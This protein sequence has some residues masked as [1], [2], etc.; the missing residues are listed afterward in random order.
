MDM[1]MF[2][3]AVIAALTISAAAG[4]VYAQMQQ[5]GPGKTVEISA[6]GDCRRI[7]NTGAHPIMV[8]TR[9]ANE[10]NKGPGAFL[11]NIKQMRGVSA[12][13]C[14]CHIWV[15]GLGAGLVDDRD[16]RMHRIGSTALTW[17]ASLGTGKGDGTA[18]ANIV[19]NGDHPNLSSL[20]SRA[21]VGSIDSIAVPA[22]ARLIWYKDRSFGGPVALDV[23]GP[24]L[25]MNGR[26]ARGKDGGW[27]SYYKNNWLTDDWSHDPDPWIRQ[28]TPETRSR[29]NRI[30]TSMRWDSMDNPLYELEDGSLRLTCGG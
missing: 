24:A 6:H 9:S 22:G 17:T 19:E 25:L 14:S 20:L 28:F 4:P 3:G 1:R 13:P 8:P 5:V 2:F 11:S 27:T 12:E 7:K 26:T 10:W 30:L 29:P 16:Q 23:T 21:A 18:G 15:G